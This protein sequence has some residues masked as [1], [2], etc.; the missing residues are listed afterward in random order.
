MII[1][2]ISLI[3]AKK[4]KTG[5][6][7]CDWPLA[8]EVLV[9]QKQCAFWLH[10]EIVILQREQKIIRNF[11]KA[12]SYSLFCVWVCVSVHKYAVFLWRSERTTFGSWLSLPTIGFGDWIQVARF[13]EPS[14]FAHWV[15]FLVI[16][17][18]FKIVSLYVILVVLE[19][20][21]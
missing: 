3:N 1:K 13:A 4:L 16:V 10:T 7:S 20:V 8:S 11:L 21:L 17:I 12:T 5:T 15:I 9:K 6:F 19:L 14:A 18:I 2:H